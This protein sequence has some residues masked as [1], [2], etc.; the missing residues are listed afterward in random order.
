MSFEIEK[1]TSQ[2]DEVRHGG[3]AQR[4]NMDRGMSAAWSILELPL[5]LIGR[6]VEGASCDSVLLC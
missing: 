1:K 4:A 5:S 2:I 6:G 3:E